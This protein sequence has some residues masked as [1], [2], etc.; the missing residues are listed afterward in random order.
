M[1]EGHSNVTFVIKRGDELFVLRRPP[2]PPRPPSAHDMLREAR[3]LRAVQ[4]RIRTPAVLAVCD[5]ESLLGVPVL[6]DGAH[7]GQR[8]HQH[9]ARAAGQPRPTTRASPTS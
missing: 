3:V 9:A 6:R 5:D 7:A 4:G 8:D 2:R 1:G